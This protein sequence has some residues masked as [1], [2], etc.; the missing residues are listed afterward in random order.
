M[1]TVKADEAAR[2]AE[3]RI[4]QGVLAA[5]MVEPASAELPEIEFWS[6][7]GATGTSRAEA[8]SDIDVS[9]AVCSCVG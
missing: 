3:E 8:S 5:C 2:L 6:F 4:E 9:L 1:S 7:V